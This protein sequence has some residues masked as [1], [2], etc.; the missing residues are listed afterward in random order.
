MGN[1]SLALP[2]GTLDKVEEQEVLRG[3]LRDTFKT[4]QNQ[5]N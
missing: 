5:K 1:I 4:K 3:N 2:L